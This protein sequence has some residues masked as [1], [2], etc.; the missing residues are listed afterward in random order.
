[1]GSAFTDRSP[2]HRNKTF[3]LSLILFS[4]DF[5]HTYSYSGM[6]LVGGNILVTYVR[7]SR[8]IAFSQKTQTG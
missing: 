1:M 3:L 7:V 4:M 5:N 6:L 2:D 8:S